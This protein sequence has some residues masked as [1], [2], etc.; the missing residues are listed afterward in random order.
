MTNCVKIWRFGIELNWGFDRDLRFTM[1]P[2]PCKSSDFDSQRFMIYNIG[3]AKTFDAHYSWT[4]KKSRLSKYYR[5][6]RTILGRLRYYRRWRCN[7]SIKGKLLDLTSEKSIVAEKRFTFLSFGP[8][9]IAFASAASF[10][11][12]YLLTPKG[13]PNDEDNKEQNAVNGG[14]LGLLRK[15]AE[16]M[17]SAFGRYVAKLHANYSPTSIRCFMHNIM[18]S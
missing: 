2:E 18:P 16:D 12:I 9:L 3:K 14:T 11:K 7:L 5:W 4:K 1:I 10:H 17:R 6:V 8:R 13:R 15:L